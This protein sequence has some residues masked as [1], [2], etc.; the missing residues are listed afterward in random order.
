MIAV[1][2][3]VVLILGYAEFEPKFPNFTIVW[4][5]VNLIFV[6]TAEEALFRKL[7]QEKIDRLPSF[8]QSY[9]VTILISSLIFGLAHFKGGLPYIGLATIAGLF[10]GHIFHTTKRIEGPILL[11]FT[12][13]F[14]HFLLFTY[15]SIGFKN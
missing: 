5:L 10:Y 3:P 4:A 13:N 11:H 8:N 15:P 12:F 9:V 2:L 7:I 14:T 1:I 6:C